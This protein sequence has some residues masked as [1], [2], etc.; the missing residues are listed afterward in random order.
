MHNEG[1]NSS[2][3]QRSQRGQ[4]LNFERDYRWEKSKKSNRKRAMQRLTS[5]KHKGR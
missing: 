4:L 2:N 5:P 3:K 1:E